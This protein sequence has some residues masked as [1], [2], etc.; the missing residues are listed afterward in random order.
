MVANPV[1][2]KL[3]AHPADYPH[4]GSQ[5]YSMSVLLQICEYRETWL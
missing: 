3:V 1:R 5:R 4:V 2:A